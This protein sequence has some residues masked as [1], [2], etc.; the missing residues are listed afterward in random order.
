MA[1]QNNKYSKK[2]LDDF[3]GKINA[4]KDAVLKDIVDSQD[5]ADNM[6]EN[7]NTSGNIYILLI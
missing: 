7:S 3:K 4:K 6:V 5:I 1:E 2:E